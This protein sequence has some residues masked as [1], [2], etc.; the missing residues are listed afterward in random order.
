MVLLRSDCSLQLPLV[1]LA[2]L[3]RW[4]PSWN[5]KDRW[6]NVDVLLENCLPRSRVHYHFW[7]EYTAWDG[8]LNVSGWRLPA[9]SRS[10]TGRSRNRSNIW[11]VALWSCSSY[12]SHRTHPHDE[13]S[14]PVL[15]W[16]VR[17]R[18][19]LACWSGLGCQRLPGPQQ[20]RY[21]LT[22]T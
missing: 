10:Y 15:C 19:I 8:W 16:S 11:S 5:R 9:R 17:L 4:S 22:E 20:S 3:S 1:L 18:S 14:S 6:T 7:W 2:M 13:T 21:S 12:R